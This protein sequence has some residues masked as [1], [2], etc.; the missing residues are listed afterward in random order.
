MMIIWLLSVELV[1]FSYYIYKSLEIILII[2]QINEPLILTD[3]RD[4]QVVIQLEFLSVAIQSGDKA[5]SRKT[6]PK[7][8]ETKKNDCKTSNL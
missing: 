1:L 6:R 3:P 8:L 5:A 7:R 4:N 2:F